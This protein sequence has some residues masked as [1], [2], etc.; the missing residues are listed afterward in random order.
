MYIGQILQGKAI[1]SRWGL[2]RRREKKGDVLYRVRPRL[3]GRKTPPGL[4]YHVPPPSTSRVVGYTGD[5]PTGGGQEL[6]R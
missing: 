3:S 4:I 2:G 1:R 6:T 5:S